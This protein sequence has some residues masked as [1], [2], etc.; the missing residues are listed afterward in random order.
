MGAV[1]MEEQVQAPVMVSLHDLE[2]SKYPSS[3]RESPAL[4]WKSTSQLLTFIADS[5]PFSTLEEA[6][7]PASLG[8]LIV[9]DLPQDF[10]PLRTRLLSYAS[11]LAQLP[12]SERG[13]SA[14]A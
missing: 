1:T 6:F 12:Q 13:K 10:A 2:T 5:V 3:A 8:I 4:F 9:K 14:V 11:Y 7:G